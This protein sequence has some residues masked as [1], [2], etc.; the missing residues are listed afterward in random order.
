MFAHCPIYGDHMVNL[1]RQTMVKLYWPGLYSNI[2]IHWI[3]RIGCSQ[4]REPYII[5]RSDVVTNIWQHIN[6]RILNTQ[7]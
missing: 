5:D 4:R 7:C 2:N 6:P 3:W 1:T